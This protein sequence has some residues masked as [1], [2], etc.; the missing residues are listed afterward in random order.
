MIKNNFTLIARKLRRNQTDV[1]KVLWYKLRNRQLKG[2]KFHRQY[3][4]GPY[5]VDFV[6]LEHFLIIELDGGQH[7]ENRKDLSRT[8]FLEQKGFEVL[9]FWNHEVLENIE[10]VEV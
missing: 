2:I 5:I 3:Q 4:I 1:E 10:G 7:A 9:R 6:C 8:K